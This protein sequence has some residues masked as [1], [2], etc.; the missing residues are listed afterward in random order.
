VTGN[1]AAMAALD[2][3]DRK[4]LDR[5]IDLSEAALRDPGKTPFGSLVVCDGEIAG[6]GAA[7]VVEQSDPTAHA[8]VVALRRA[9]S[10]LQR[11]LLE[12]AT[13]YSS[14]EPC[15]MCLAACYW[16][17]ISRVV[18]S[19]TSRDVAE[20]GFEDLQFYRELRYSPDQR[21]L[22]EDAAGR[23]LRERAAAVLRSW[24]GQFPGQVEPK[25]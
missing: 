16:A 21:S 25:Y 10:R 6:E 4:F 2:E 15:P 17:R 20:N 22:P 1:Y 7:S 24:A 3:T 5:A 13:L 8:E 23:P 9:G 19:A 14:S 12:G 18:F 11:H